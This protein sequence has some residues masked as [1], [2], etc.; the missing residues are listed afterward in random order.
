MI[1]KAGIDQFV[2]HFLTMRI[3]GDIDPA[4]PGM[5]YLADRFEINRNQRYWLAWLYS[6]NY[7]LPTTYYIFSEFPD[8][9]CVEVPR[10]QLWWAKNK[11]R[12]LFQTDRSWVHKNDEFVSMFVSYR[13]EIGDDPEKV[14]QGKTYRQIFEYCRNL[15]YFQRYSLFLYLE[16]MQRL[17]GLPIE[18]DTIDLKS[19]RTVCNALAI[20]N[21]TSEWIHNKKEGQFDY[22][23]IYWM[24]ELLKELKT[25]LKMYNYW[26][27]ETALCA[28]YKFK[29]GR[30]YIGYYI[31]RMQSEIEI[32]QTVEGVDW[33]VLWDFRREYFDHTYLGEYN[34]WNGLRNIAY[35][36]VQPK[37]H[38]TIYFEKAGSCYD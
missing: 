35:N 9:E 33:S 19:S 14:F 28:Y 38:K 17:T 16:S 18:P 31:D 2:E 5:I 34:N 4:Y 32:M 37:P 22:G 36:R 21:G 6:T 29:I 26:E 7:C 15:H 23:K 10:L 13:N 25:R 1:A 12:L 30:R 24:N 8:Y 11:H 27:I 20:I 3:I